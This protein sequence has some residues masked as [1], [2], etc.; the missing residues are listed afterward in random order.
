MLF[1]LKIKK[2]NGNPIETLSVCVVMHIYVTRSFNDNS[3]SP[4]EIGHY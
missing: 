2:D 3:H 4:N 1:N